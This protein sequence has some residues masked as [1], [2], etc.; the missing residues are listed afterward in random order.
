MKSK[1]NLLKLREVNAEAK[2]QGWGDFFRS[3]T[4]LYTAIKRG[5]IPYVRVNGKYL[6]RVVDV[7]RALLSQTQAQQTGIRKID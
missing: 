4:A 5:I 3:Y 7:E 1:E 6:I 2:E